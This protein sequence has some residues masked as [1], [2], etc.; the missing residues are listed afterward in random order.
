MIPFLWLCLVLCVLCAW[1]VLWPAA[2]GRKDKLQQEDN[3]EWFHLRARELAVEGGEELQRDAQLRLLEDAQVPNEG[4]AEEMAGRFRAWLILPII[5]IVSALLYFQLG[6]MPDVVLTEK[7]NTLGSDTSQQEMDALVRA[8]ELRSEQ[9]PDNLYYLSLLGRFHMGQSDYQAA[10]QIY[11]SLLQAVPTDPQALAFAAQ[12]DYLAANRRLGDAAKLRAETALAADP[13]QATALGLLGMAAYEQGEFRGAISYWER[14]L[15]VH[16]GDSE[17]AR[18]IEGVI[19]N[20]RQQLGE[21]APMVEEGVEAQP[22]TAGV[23]VQVSLPEGVTVAGGDTVFVLARDAISDSRM[24]IAVERHTGSQLPLTLR[25]DDANSMAGQKIS[26]MASV[27]VSVQISPD[28]RPGEANAT[29]VGNSDPVTPSV[30][31][32]VI[33]LKLQAN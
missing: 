16:S 14:L 6:G 26:Q 22:L 5:F 15:A 31:G 2:K 4:T 10:L 27:I 9:R 33:E 24:P 11:E 29:W 20:A 32:E 17:S 12:A 3:L 23:T 13:R 25:L 8:V 18:M 7:L 28:G 19:A 30:A 21:T 1:F